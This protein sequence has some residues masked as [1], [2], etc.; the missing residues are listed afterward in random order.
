MP[1][2]LKELDGF[3]LVALDG[4]IGH[5][6]EAYF[7]DRHWTIRHLVVD[8][9]GWLTGR[10][11]LVSPHAVR[12][13]DR[14]G[15]CI[16]VALERR[17]VETAPD[18]DTARP[19]SRQHEMALYDHHGWP[20]WWSGDALWGRTAYPVVAGTVLAPPPSGAGLPPSITERMRAQRAD[21]DPHLRSSAEVTGYHIEASDGSIGHIDDF[22]FDEHSWSIAFVVVVVVVVVVVDAGHWLPGRQ[23]LIAPRWIEHID[24]GERRA[25]VRLSRAAVESSPPYRRGEPL[26]E[27]QFL[28]VQHHFER[29]E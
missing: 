9:G 6:K 23:V 1:Y 11:V 16:E 21:D 8:T 28:R 5:A 3:A 29:S 19:V 26:R 22:L 7:D 20:Y 14:D 15:R 13:I 2:S 12:R 18:I 25:R 17:R 24:W 27:D 10:K 4:E